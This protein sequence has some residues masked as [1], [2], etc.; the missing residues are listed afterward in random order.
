[1]EMEMEEERTVWLSVARDGVANKY[2][3][4]VYC[5]CRVLGGPHRENCEQTDGNLFVSGVARQAQSVKVEDNDVKC[6]YRAPPT[7]NR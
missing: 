6:G 5:C 3:G 7:P 1:M 4:V 2:N